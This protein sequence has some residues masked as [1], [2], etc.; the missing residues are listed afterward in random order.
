MSVCVCVFVLGGYPIKQTHPNRTRTVS[1][2][3]ESQE[4]AKMSTNLAMEAE[5]RFQKSAK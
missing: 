4:M 3:K 5:P 2:S 1:S